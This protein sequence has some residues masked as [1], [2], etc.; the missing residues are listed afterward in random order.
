MPR[1]A[2]RATATGTRGKTKG[3]GDSK[4]FYVL[5]SMS[6][7]SC[8]WKNWWHGSCLASYTYYDGFRPPLPDGGFLLL[9]TVLLAL[10][11]DAFLL[12]LL[13]RLWGDEKLNPSCSIRSIRSWVMVVGCPAWN[14]RYCLRC[15][16]IHSDNGRCSMPVPGTL[17][18]PCVC[19][20]WTRSWNRSFQASS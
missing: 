15:A 7:L 11:S 5:Y 18:C 20:N 8:N 17:Q 10:L 19:T 1:R 12:D 13:R 4:T 9:V 6:P 16:L 14:S 2:K 3:H